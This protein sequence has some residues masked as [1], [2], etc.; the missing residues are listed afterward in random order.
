MPVPRQLTH[1]VAGRASKFCNGCAA[2]LCSVL[3]ASAGPP[4]INQGGCSGPSW[5]LGRAGRQLFAL[6][7]LPCRL[8]VFQLLKSFAVFLTLYINDFFLLSFI[9]SDKSFYDTVSIFNLGG[10]W[11]IN[12]KYKLYPRKF[13]TQDFS[14]WLKVKHLNFCLCPENWLYENI[15]RFGVWA[16]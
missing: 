16:T 9:L 4:G 12:I 6:P 15:P 5:M 1:E 10:S 13:F 2:C 11:L 3:C 14:F 8:E 7:S